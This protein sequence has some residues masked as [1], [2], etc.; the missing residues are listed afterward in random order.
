[1]RDARISRIE[2]NPPQLPQ[3]GWLKL[4]LGRW[5]NGRFTSATLFSTLLYLSAALFAGLIM[6]VPI[7]LIVR[8]S[9]A[10]QEAVQT[11]TR[12]STL[13]VIGNTVLLTASVTV[14]STVIALPLAWL[15]TRTDLPGRKVWAVLHALPLVIPSY[16]Y[17]FL[18]LSFLSPKGLLQQFLEWTI[19]LDRL[20]PIY[21][22]SGAFIVLT[23]ISYPFIFLT[24]SA[25]LRQMDPTLV[26]VAQT[27]GATKRQILHYVL[28]PYLRPSLLAGGLLVALYCL[29]DF[30]AVTLLQFS[31]FT[32]VIYN[33]YQ[34]MRLDDAATMA[35]VLVLMTGI[36]M[37]LESRMR[38][39]REEEM[40]DEVCDGHQ[41]K[42]FALGSWR[43]PALIFSGIISFLALF[44]PI[45][46]LGYWV[47]RGLQQDGLAANVSAVQQ[48]T[49]VFSQLITP[50]QSSIITALMTALLA[51]VV[52]VPIV[53]LSVR[54]KGWWAKAFE[55][56]SYASYALPGIVVAL[57]FAYT[58]INF[59]RPLYQTVPMLIAAYLVLFV[60]QAVSAERSALAQIPVELEEVGYS[61]GGSKWDIFRYVTL[62]LM[63][64]GLV[65]AG[66]L[67]FLTVMKEL[68]VTLLLSPLGFRTLPTL[69]W[70][71]INEAFFAKAAVPT[72][73]LL[74]VSS[75]PLAWF[76]IKQ[77]Q[78]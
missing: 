27:N 13:K 69:V 74:L 39:E 71:N 17:A 64:P 54:Y 31:T 66:L 53:I 45:G 28:V 75:F 21:G 44:M 30:G 52:A 15:T 60:P 16:I 42:R 1:M 49:A 50:A 51:I 26:E 63:R 77:N 73:L 76:S 43:T 20:P 47:A 48:N 35:L 6:L 56:L 8:T 4:G 41:L 70:S 11:L 55:R 59:V 14:A 72:L 68:P 23:L 61:M 34:G 46:V 29:R 3:L 67:V 37:L 78:D 36:I 18:F 25:A 40:G 32:S 58:G 38:R 24:V 33:R 2:Y 7:Y 19:G 22:F 9:S 57:A 62:P 5:L 12:L 10:W 65:A